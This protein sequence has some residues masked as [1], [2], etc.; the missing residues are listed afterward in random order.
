MRELDQRYTTESDTID[1]QTWYKLLGTFDDANIYQ[2]WAYG[3]VRSGRKNISHL[4]LRKQGQVVAIAQARIRRV[5]LIG[6][7]IAYVMWGPLWRPSGGCHDVEVFR[8]VIR[9]LRNEYVC[10]R[11]LL[12]R[13]YPG[14]FEQDSHGVLSILQEEGFARAGETGRSMTLVM[15]LDRSLLELRSGLRPHW[16]RELKVADKQKMEI[17]E[18][19]DDE[20]IGRFIMMY[21][22]MVA[23]KQFRE[24]NN[25]EEFR[26]V[27]QRLP[28]EYKMRVMLCGD[29]KEDF[30]GSICSAIGKTAL[31]L[32]GVTSNRGMKTRGSYLLQWKLL[33]WLKD[34]GI[35]HYDLNGI[36]P[37]KNPGTYKFKSDMGGDK[38]RVVRFLGQFDSC[39]SMVSRVCVKVAE[40]LKAVL[41]GST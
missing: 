27:Q 33:E 38:G 3:E 26:A 41:G 25:I 11:G 37:E 24:P 39:Q 1:E 22:E 8:Q 31:Y 18:G 28:Q 23:R 13:V 35:P 15:D 17:I 4:V 34:H 2:T 16:Q 6:A 21:R 19:Y 20:L 12:L 7:G 32:F 9:A 10:N 14:L 30:A 40:K 5:P 29:G 36:N